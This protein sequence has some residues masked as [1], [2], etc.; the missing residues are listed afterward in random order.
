MKAVAGYPPLLGKSLRLI[1]TGQ[2]A[3]ITEDV[4]L[5]KSE[6][7]PIFAEYMVEKVTS[8]TFRCNCD[9]FKRRGCCSHSLA[10]FIH[11]SQKCKP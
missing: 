11:E 3:K 4:F 1:Q 7:N 5:V 9:G 6:S 8:D 2:V 10:V